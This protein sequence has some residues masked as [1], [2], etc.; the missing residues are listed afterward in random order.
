VS[1]LAAVVLA[2]T[3]PAQLKR[4][5]AALDDVPVV[6]HCDARAKAE[7]ARQMLTGLPR[8]VEVCDRIPTSRES[9]SLVEAELAALR[10][11]LKFSGARHIAVL[12]GMDY[13]LVSMQALVDE[14]A[15]WAGHSYFRNVPMPFPEWNTRRYQDGGFWR[16][17]HRFFRMGGRILHWRGIPL[18]WPIRRSLPPDLELRAASQWKIYARHHVELLLHLVEMRPDLIR[19]WRSTLIPDETFAASML[20][21]RAIAGS[22]HMPACVA[23]AWFM[24]WPEFDWHPRWLTSEDFARIEQ[25]RR[26]PSIEFGE[27]T[28]TDGLEIRTHRKLFARKFSTDI[29]ADVLDQ[30]D[31]ELRV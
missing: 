12:S 26:A 27:A 5:V 1:E 31:A 6:I 2:H 14:L 21:S 30:V 3:D 29:D 4:L 11:A 19:F 28:R 18:H 15:G 7:V 10:R 9:W 20:G 17:T 25:A 13:P 16:V 23:N 22:A 24:I 8:R